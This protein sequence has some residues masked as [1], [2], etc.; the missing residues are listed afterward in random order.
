MIEVKNIVKHYPG[1]E[2]NC[3]LKSE[4]GRITGVIGQNGAGKS[5]LFRIILSLAK[6]EEGTV[7]IDGQDIRTMR[8]QDRE[9][10]GT[11]MADSTFSGYLTIDDVR[12]LLKQ[13]Y[14]DISDKYKL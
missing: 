1:F 12:I 13:F 9:K 3:S 6:A 11:V 14:P 5:T 2:L 10:I 7:V 8:D 4:N